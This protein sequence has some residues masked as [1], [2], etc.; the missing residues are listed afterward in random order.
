ML[1]KIK[2]PKREYSNKTVRTILALCE[3]GKFFA[4]ITSQVKV[5]QP[6]IVY[7][8]HRVSCTLTEPY[9]PI[10]LVGRKS[11][12]DTQAQKILVCHLVQSPNDNLMSFGKLFNLGIMLSRK[13]IPKYQKAKGYLQ[14]KA[15]RKAFWTKKHKKVRLHLTPK[16]LK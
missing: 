12:L 16:H 14:F 15:Q 5:S 11:N 6:S 13:T 7:I 10:C 2:I 4:Q 9:R 8:I 1:L 3:V